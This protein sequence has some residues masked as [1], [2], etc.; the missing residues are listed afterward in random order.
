[1]TMDHQTASWMSEDCL[2]G[3]CGYPVIGTQATEPTCD[4]WWYC[5]NKA[6]M[7]HIGTQHGDQEEVP[8]VRKV[9]KIGGGDMTSMN[10]RKTNF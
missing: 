6:C 10:E 9:E 7:N 2:C 5:S 1:M 3:S 4:Y 8:W